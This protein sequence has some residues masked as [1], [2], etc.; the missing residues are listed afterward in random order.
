L[1]WGNVFVKR[2]IVFFSTRALRDEAQALPERRSADMQEQGPGDGKGTSG[3]PARGRIETAMLEL[4]GEVG[5]RSVTLEL[6]LSRS[7]AASEEFSA[8]FTDLEACFAAAYEAEAESVCAAMLAAAGTGRDWRAATEAALNIVL[9]LAAERPTIARALVREVHIAGG[10]VVARHEELL[11]R[12]ARAMG[13]DCR[14]STSEMSVPRAPSFIVGAVEGVIS[15]HL[16]RG[17]AE[18]LLTAAPELMDLIAIFFV[19]RES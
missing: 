2:D 16:D 19:G 5:Y 10:V 9:E 11:A 18:E 17:E 3:L 14:H 12:L 4:S 6:L 1:N 13:E 15:G 7:G 8:S